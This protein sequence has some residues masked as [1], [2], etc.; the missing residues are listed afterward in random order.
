M[1]R[2]SVALWLIPSVSLCLGGVRRGLF[3]QES[4]SFRQIPSVPDDLLQR[5]VPLRAG[6]GTADDAVSTTVP[7]AQGFYDQ[8]LAYLHSY[9][10]VEAARSFHHA[11]KLD[12]TLAMAEVGLS[13]AYTELNA[14]A[15]ARAALDRARAHAADLS[16]HDRRHLDA[17]AAQMAAEDEPHAAGR[18]AAYRQGLDEAL[19]RFPSDEEFWLLRGLAVSSDPAHP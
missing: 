14:P 3:A 5:P 15:F 9:V 1:L 17:R 4:Q 13:V 10:W 7:L 8:G 12:P 2:V 6:I 11:L 18:L 19:A 16:D